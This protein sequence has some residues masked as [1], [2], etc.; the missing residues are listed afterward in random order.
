M[1]S[2][3][4][5]FSG[6]E[7]CLKRMPVESVISTKRTPVAASGIVRKVGT[8]TQKSNTGMRAGRATISSHGLGSPRSASEGIL[9]ICQLF[10]VCD[11]SA[12]APAPVRAE[13]LEFF[14]PSGMPVQVGNDYKPCWDRAARQSLVRRFLARSALLP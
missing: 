9:V 12:R 10:P 6:A 4:Y 1:D 8:A 2:T 14:L 11:P 3:M 7:T 13:P 5:F